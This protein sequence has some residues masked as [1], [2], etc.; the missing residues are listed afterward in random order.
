MSE[1][2]RV[3]QAAIEAEATMNDPLP[4]DAPATRP[5]RTVPVSVRL[6]PAMVAEIEALA[7]R[8]EI[9]S[10]TLLRGWIQQGL[11]A[12]HQTT[13]AGALDQ[14]AADLQRLRQIV[15]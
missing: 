10:S 13:V 15:A 4:D 11:A 1:Q 9:P 12:H 8:L 3:R 5:N 14:L 7:K 6:S 2:D